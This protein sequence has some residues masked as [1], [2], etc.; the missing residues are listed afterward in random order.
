M[1]KRKVEPTEIRPQPR[2]DLDLC[3]GSPGQVAKEKSKTES[4]LL[5]RLNIVNCHAGV[6][7]VDRPDQVSYTHLG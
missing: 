2:V 4:I 1:E 6:G 3:N 7:V 5:N